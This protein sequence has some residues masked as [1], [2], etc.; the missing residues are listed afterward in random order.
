[1]GGPIDDWAGRAAHTHPIIDNHALFNAGRL[2]G[3]QYIA[4]SFLTY[5]AMMC[6]D[7]NRLR[8]LV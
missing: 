4:F 1:M 3:P 5:G 2:V 8:I 7:E 6:S